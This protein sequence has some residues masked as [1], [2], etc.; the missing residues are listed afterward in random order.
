[1]QGAGDFDT[2]SDFAGGFELAEAFVAG[3]DN[4]RKVLVQR[5]GA[6]IG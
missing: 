5:E 2:C 1:M 6:D 3:G 4:L